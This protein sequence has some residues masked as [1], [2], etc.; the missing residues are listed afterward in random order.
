MEC[1]PRCCLA[2]SGAAAAG[3]EAGLDRVGRVGGHGLVA[4]QPPHHLGE[5]RAALFLAVVAGG[6]DGGG[7]E[8]C[9]AGSAAGERCKQA[10]GPP[11]RF[12]MGW[13][14]QSQLTKLETAEPLA[15]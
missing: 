11:R 12:F 5:D 1:G 6:A 10:R 13:L 2:G 4:P 15:V 3:A 14:R 7:V 9:W 8:G